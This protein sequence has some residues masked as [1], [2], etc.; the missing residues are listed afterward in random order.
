MAIEIN[1]KQLFFDKWQ[2]LRWLQD[3]AGGH[4]N[5]HM[6]MTC[7]KFKM[8]QLIDLLC[9]DDKSDKCKINIIAEQ[10]KYWLIQI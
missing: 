4:N 2:I 8:M 5:K 7:T 3:S 6:T 1:L 9:F 10:N